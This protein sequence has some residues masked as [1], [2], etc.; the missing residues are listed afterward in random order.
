MSAAKFRFLPSHRVSK[1]PAF[2]QKK[3]SKRHENDDKRNT[4]IIFANITVNFSNKRYSLLSNPI[5]H[6]PPKLPSK[7]IIPLTTPMFEKKKERVT[8]F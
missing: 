2:L 5:V 1:A 6:P 8:Q 7:M 4:Y 3:E